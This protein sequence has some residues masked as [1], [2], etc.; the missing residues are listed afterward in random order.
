MSLQ[1]LQDIVLELFHAMNTPYSLVAASM[2]KQGMWEDLVQLRAD[3]QTYTNADQYR[4]DNYACTLLK[5][6]SGLPTGVDTVLAAKQSWLAAE[7]QCYVTNRRLY[8]ELDSGNHMSEEFFRHVRSHFYR[9]VG[10]APSDLNGR[11]GPGSVFEKMGRYVSIPDKIASQPT[12][13]AGAIPFIYLYRQTAWERSDNLFCDAPSDLSELIYLS[14][15]R[16]GAPVYLR[17]PRERHYEVIRGNR[18]GSALKN[19]LTDRSI[20][21]E[22]SLN[23]Y[24][25]LGVGRE[26]RRNLQRQGL[27]L[28]PKKRKPGYPRTNDLS[29][30]Q[31]LHRDLARRG[32]IDGSVATIDAIQASDTM[33]TALVER[34]SGEQW[35][36]LLSELRSPFTRID[37]AWYKLEKF[38]SMGNGFTFEL[39]TAIFAAI[40]YTVADSMQIELRTGENFS[41]YGDDIIVPTEMAQAMVKALEYCGFGINLSKSFLD[42]PFRESC[43]GD[44]FRGHPV[45]GLYLKQV[46]SSVGDWIVFYNLVQ[47]IAQYTPVGRAL[48]MIRDHIPSAL[49]NYGPESLGDVVLHHPFWERKAT[50]KRKNDI[51]MLKVTRP[52]IEDYPLERWGVSSIVASKLYGLTGDRI[53]F[54]GNPISFI[55]AWVNWG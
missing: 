18:W 41:V 7:K 30:S 29:E 51:L 38:S 42:G 39:E 28:A 48:H 23:V 19:C 13:T 44:Y 15:S 6:C 53:A 33:A 36:H 40:A 16:K 35:F 21:I 37:N 12:L 17:E 32:S 49:R 8:E 25:Q 4:L 1:H 2:V 43:G 14:H 20:G 9:L 3:P 24:Y 10:R 46:P 45:R 52:V 22:P 27:L 54:R 5:K 50:I 34:A 31:A 55:T 26:M 47:E 11:F